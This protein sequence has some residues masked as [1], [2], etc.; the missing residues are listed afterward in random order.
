MPAQL[1]QNDRGPGEP[2]ATADRVPAGSREPLATG[3]DEERP[4]SEGGPAA[5]SRTSSGEEPLA[6]ECRQVA[7]CRRVAESSGG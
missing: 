2:L 7:E 3:A 5:A 4:L 6:G 1:K